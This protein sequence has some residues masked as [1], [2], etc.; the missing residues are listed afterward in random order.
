MARS[1]RI[2]PFRLL[3]GWLGVPEGTEQVVSSGLISSVIRRDDLHG[4]PSR[5]WT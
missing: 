1:G 2:R 4:D 5:A 3:R